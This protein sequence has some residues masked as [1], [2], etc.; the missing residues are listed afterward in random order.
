MFS[1]S[2]LYDYLNNYYVAAKN[3]KE[4]GELYHKGEGV[5]YKTKSLVGINKDYVGWINIEDTTVDYP[6]VKTGDNEFYL[7]HNF[8]KQEDFAG[9]IFMDYRNS[10]DKLDKNLILYG[11]NMK[12]GSMFGSLKNYLEEDYLKKTE[13]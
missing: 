4:L 12:D 10:M 5:K 7:S 9:A 13:L 2:S 11:H 6:V 8:Y 1:L 3:Y